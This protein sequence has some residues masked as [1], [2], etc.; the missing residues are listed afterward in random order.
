MTE[1]P[2]GTVTFLITDIEGSTQRWEH[3]PETMR[4]SVAQHD[5]VL[6]TAIEANGG[7]PFKNTGDGILAAFSSARSAIDAAI[8]AQRGLELPVRMGICTGEVELRVD[9]YFGPALNRAARTMAAGHGGQV[10]VAASTAALVEGV[11]LAD[12]GEHRLRD[13]SQPQ[14]LYQVRGEGLKKDFPALKT[15]DSAPGNLPTQASSFLGREKDLAQV[16][17]LLHGSRL[18]TL[19][20]VGGVG[21][22]RL[23][24]Q[25]AAE[26]SAN[27][28]DGTWLVELAAVGDPDSTAPAIAGVFGIAQQSGKTVGQSIVASL[29]RRRLLL[30]LDNCEHLIDAAAA[31]AADIATQCPQ[32]TVLATS[33]EA[34]MVDGERIWPVPSLAFRDGVASPAVQLFA[35]RARAVMPQ[36]ELDADAQAVS[37]ICHRLD[38]IPLA[39]ELA[40]A[41]IRA[42]SPRQILAR[43]DDRFRLLTGGSRRALERHQT[44]RH[45]VQWSYDLLA[46]GE[47]VLLARC[48]V[49][50][51][52]FTLE[53]AEYVG[54]GR[55][56]A[57]ADVLDLLDSLVR[58]S[59][60][61]A[62]R[63]ND[64]M[65]Y[66]LLETI[67]QFAEE[68]L[69]AIGEMEA[70]HLRHA[71]FFAEDSDVHFRVWRS[72][73][74]R[75]G[76][77]WVDREIDNLRA[78]FRWAVDHNDIEIAARIAGVGEMARDRLREEAAGWSAE[79]VDAAY[80]VRYQRLPI[81]LTW[82]AS[83][84]WALGRWEE[85]KRYGEQ[86]IALAEDPEFEPFI[87]AYGDL[88]F[89][90]AYDGD[91]DRALSLAQTGATKEADRYDRMCLAH[92]P[93]FM[94]LSGRHQEAMAAS[95]DIVATVEA[96]GLPLAL[97]IACYGKGHAF[98]GSDPDIAL[99][100]FER[101][102]EVA[103][104]S[105]NRMF[106]TLAIPEIAALQARNGNM[107]AALGSFRGMLD[108]WRGTPEALLISHGIGGLVVLLER[109][110]RCETAA[111]LHGMLENAFPSNPCVEE[112]PATMTRLRGALDK[113]MFDEISRLGAA[114]DLQK[115]IDVAQ[116]EISSALAELGQIE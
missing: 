104:N 26:V 116:G 106:E 45:A 65:R 94:A 61:T 59:L 111:L 75:V 78:A 57:A 53:A 76:H 56:L 85:A 99:A 58:K 95:D 67:R 20:G 10:L 113:S 84:A 17:T 11:E 102:V 2:I 34:L 79:I 92:V 81:L 88:A 48:S 96:A 64:T 4:T 6:R 90:A 1:R 71:Q 37:E 80:A 103:Q 97:L 33:R 114:M 12:L 23:A 35:E 46:P 40:A 54:V 77:E 89:V 13:L 3:D 91:V 14:R 42:M 55:E 100:A 87:W 51:G 22:T 101:V 7:W 68:Q 74:Q 82:A 62:E 63:S 31:L 105:G 29:S 27:Y 32:V 52:G 43:L 69:A 107:A 19:A 44:L 70:A 83:S 21:K 73:R 16:V 49:F 15:L 93:Y 110:G 9:D 30:L 72:V 109:L 25:V 18:V 115:A 28:P 60:V 5:M 47:R 41:R 50:A 8:A 112:L 39:I 98:A 86:A 108:A 36:F 66:G 38:G 24:L